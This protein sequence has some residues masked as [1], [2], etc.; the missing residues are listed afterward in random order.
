MLNLGNMALKKMFNESIFE[1][2]K[3]KKSFQMEVDN[4]GEY[5]SYSDVSFDNPMFISPYP[6]KLYCG[7]K[8]TFI[9]SRFPVRYKT[10]FRCYLVYYNDVIL[11]IPYEHIIGHTYR[12]FITNLIYSYDE[13]YYDKDGNSVYEEDIREMYL[14]DKE[15]NPDLKYKQYINYRIRVTKLPR[16]TGRYFL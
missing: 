12:W 7:D 16:Y 1:L 5:M 9:F 13:C 11:Q 2:L 14:K 10:E 6:T 4:K 15:K 8:V 3:E